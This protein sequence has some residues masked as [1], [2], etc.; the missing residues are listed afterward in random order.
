MGKILRV[1]QKVTV[2]IYVIRGSSTSRHS[3]T[4]LVRTGSRGQDFL[5][6]VIRSCTTDLDRRL[7]FEKEEPEMVLPV[8]LMQGK[9]TCFAIFSN[10]ITF[11]FSM[12][13]LPK[14]LASCGF[15]AGLDNNDHDSFSD[16][17]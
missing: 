15:I 5:E 17:K 7:H 14:L 11:I 2:L 16:K 10:L 13:T 4:N 1:K 8:Q 9:L 3:I 6:D 12:K